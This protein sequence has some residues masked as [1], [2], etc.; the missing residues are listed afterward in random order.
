MLWAVIYLICWSTLLTR[1]VFFGKI[2]LSDSKTKPN[3]KAFRK[4][5]K[6]FLKRFFD[7]VCKIDL[8]I[9]YKFF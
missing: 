7:T 3:K 1:S 5:L 9:K 2:M 6:R 4:L 8:Q